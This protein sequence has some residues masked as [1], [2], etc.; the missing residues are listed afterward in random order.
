[1]QGMPTA[2]HRP[3]VS[4]RAQ[5][6]WGARQQRLEQ[7]RGLEGPPNHPRRHG[8]CP[9]RKG[10]GCSEQRAPKCVVRRNSKG[11]CKGVLE[12]CR[13]GGARG[14]NQCGEGTWE[15]GSAARRRQTPDADRL[16]HPRRG[17]AQPG[18]TL[19]T[20]PR[21]APWRGFGPTP[22]AGRRTMHEAS[23]KHKHKHK[24]VLVGSHEDEITGATDALRG[25]MHL[26]PLDTPQRMQPTNHDPARSIFMHQHKPSAHTRLMYRLI[27]I[28]PV[29]GGQ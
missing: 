18:R 16:D 29:Q 7:V 27:P 13:I 14:C 19:P 12:S 3:R 20:D 23:Y 24:H 1:M 5:P 8:G 4:R 10:R 17:D 15:E 2:P 11:R 9:W 26:L 25:P 22:R 28:K 21:K 6:S